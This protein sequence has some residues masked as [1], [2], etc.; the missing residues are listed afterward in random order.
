MEASAK[1]KLKWWQWGLIGFFGLV[2]LR[3]ILPDPKPTEFEKQMAA[4]SFSPANPEFTL[5]GRDTYAMV[6]NAKADPNVLPEIARK[7]CKKAQFCDVLGW[8]DSK[9]A[10][11]AMPMT[12]RESEAL[13]FQY[14]LNRTSGHEKA[15]FNCHVWKRQPVECFA[16]VD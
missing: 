9:M 12:D 13:M 15:L 11:G 10:A 16:K 4:P 6:F 3:A 14:S 5:I 1:R 8:T 2:L 7:H